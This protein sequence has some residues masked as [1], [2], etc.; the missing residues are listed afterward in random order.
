[1]TWSLD[2]ADQWRIVDAFMQIDGMRKRSTRDVFISLL[3]RE[4]GQHLPIPRHEQDLYDVWQLVDVLLAYSGAVHTLVDIVGTFHGGSRS[5]TEIRNV[6]DELLPEPL[7]DGQE[8]REL[9]QLVR[10]LEDRGMKAA[11]RAAIP[12]LYRDAVGPV[13]PALDRDIRSIKAVIAQL[14]EV[15]VGMD[16]VPPLLAFVRDLAGCTDGPTATALWD[17]ARRFSQRLGLHGT[18]LR[19]LQQGTR[20]RT[21]SA[22]FGTYLVIEFRPDLAGSDMFLVTAWL[23]FDGELGS[24][25]HRDDDP[26]PLSRLPLLLE[27]LLIDNHQVVNRHTPA[28]TIEFVLPR[29]LLGIP[30]DQLRITVD[31]L[32]RR[33]G[34][35]HPVIVRSLDRIQQRVLHHNWR[36]KWSWLRENPGSVTVCW[37]AQPG[38]FDHERLYTLLSEH[39]SACLALAFPPWSGAPNPVDELWVGLQAGASAMRRRVG[40]S[41]VTT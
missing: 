17:W 27:A 34:I 12:A 18:E 10:A 2:V 14:E 40:Q 16:G 23:Q 28:L 26:F 36:R 11:H 3:E 21:D 22:E 31:G 32:E 9:H 13:G 38:E 20:S 8:R 6:V 35:E 25:L 24:T 1:V 41:A 37:I 7:L 29:S 15:A 4:L 5:M 39:S 33:L 19:Q 30:L